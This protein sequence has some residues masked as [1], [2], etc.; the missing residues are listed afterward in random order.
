MN[1]RLKQDPA[2]VMWVLIGLL[3]LIVAAIGGIFYLAG[4]KLAEQSKA[5][6]HAKIDYE[7]EEAN[8]TKLKS[9]QA[10]LN[11]NKATVDRAAEVVSESQSYTYQN[12]GIADLN[13]FASRTGVSITSIEFPDTKQQATPDKLP[14]NGVKRVPVVVNLDGPVDYSRVLKFIKSIEQNLTKMQITSVSL[15]PDAAN[16]ASLS[17]PAID[18]EVFVR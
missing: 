2:A 17:G 16:T 8:I 18:I 6:N 11:K 5:A 15:I 4:Q 7:L 1:Q 3:V 12:Q 10:Y 14:I 9:L 13:S